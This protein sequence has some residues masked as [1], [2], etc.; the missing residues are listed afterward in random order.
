MDKL[1]NTSIS[2]FLSKYL[3]HEP[4]KIGLSLDVGGWVKVDDLL[5]A[6]SKHNFV[7]SR[8]ELEEVV[9]TNA[10]QRF[11]FDPTGTLIRANQGHSVE[12]DLQLEPMQPPDVLYH[13][14]AEKN[15][16]AIGHLGLQ[17]M[18]RHHVHLSMDLVTAKMVGQRHGKPVVFEVDAAAMYKAGSIFYCSAN[19]VWLVDHVP[20]EY[21]QIC[22]KQSL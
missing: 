8:E 4:A 22:I 5:T 21:L 19:Q 9:A 17:K 15:V 6:S 16:E 2:K 3:R 18:S 20:P 14:T 13:G 7:I 10:K 1:R 12:V 11:S